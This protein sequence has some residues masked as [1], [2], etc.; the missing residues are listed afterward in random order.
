MKDLRK[1]ILEDINNYAAAKEKISRDKKESHGEIMAKNLSKMKD[2]ISESPIRESLLSAPRNFKP[3]GKIESV[4]LFDTTPKLPIDYPTKFSEIKSRN[5]L[6]HRHHAIIY[7]FKA[8]ANYIPAVFNPSDIEREFGA[9][10]KQAFYTIWN[11]KGANY[12]PPT[13]KELEICIPF[14]EE[15][16]NA[17]KA[18]ENYLDKLK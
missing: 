5:K 9:K 1:Q 12:R 13:A 15:F 18:A 10:R 17:K 7:K 2:T 11:E 14:L 4:F 6:N 16:P 3:R 8:E